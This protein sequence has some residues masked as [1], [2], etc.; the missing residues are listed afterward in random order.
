MS[1]S[2]LTV[3]SSP[4]ALR[5]KPKLPS[6]AF[7]GLACVFPLCKLF[8]GPCLTQQIASA[9]SA[10]Q[11]AP[12]STQDSII[13]I[14]CLLDTG[15]SCFQHSPSGLAYKVHLSP[16]HFP[17]LAQSTL[18]RRKLPA[19]TPGTCPDSGA[20]TA[21]TTCHTFT[22]ACVVDVHLCFEGLR[23]VGA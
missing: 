9:C 17:D 8:P 23:S 12:L 18:P 19:H 1:P 21:L 15:H 16:V 13:F 5:I 11:W 4:R 14:L 20:F 3:F 2:Y 7:Q 22:S 6:M 10:G